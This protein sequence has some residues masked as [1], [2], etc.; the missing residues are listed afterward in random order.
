DELI[1]LKTQGGYW[2][3][4]NSIS[5]LKAFKFYFENPERFVKKNSCG[6]GDYALNIKYNGEATFCS[7][8]GNI[9]N[10]YKDGIKDMW[11]SDKALQLRQKMKQCSKNCHFL[12]NCY[13]AETNDESELIA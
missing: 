6:L 5:Q 2:K 10:I 3:I 1:R 11:H 9:G 12:I 7:K 13:R 4:T 8:L